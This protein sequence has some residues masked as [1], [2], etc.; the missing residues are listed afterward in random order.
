MFNLIHTKG[1]YMSTK[2][3]HLC[4]FGLLWLV[5]LSL[6][7]CIQPV[8][9]QTTTAPVANQSVRQGLKPGDKVG[10]MTLVK[11]PGKFGPETPPWAAFC[12]VSPEED[13]TTGTA[14]PG[15]YFVECNIPFVP[16]LYIGFPWLTRDEKLR[17]SIWA[18]ATEEHYLN[19]QLI[20]EAAFGT[21][22]TDFPMADPNTTNKDMVAKIRAWN[23]LLD[24]LTPGEFWLREV[25]HA[26]QTLAIG[27]GSTIP[28]GTYDITWKIT[29]AAPE[30]TTTADVTT[31]NMLTMTNP[32]MTTTVTQT[33]APTMTAAMTETATPTTT[34]AA[35]C[36]DVTYQS[37]GAPVRAVLCQPVG[38]ATQLPALIFLHGDGGASVLPPPGAPLG[39]EAKPMP[40]GL[41]RDLALKGYVTLGI[42]YFSQTPAPGP[43]PDSFDAVAEAERLKYTPT[44][45]RII[46]D[47]VTFLQSQPRV[48]PTRLGL[49]GWSRGGYLAL[50]DGT[51]NPAYRAVV[52]ISGFADADFA[53]HVTKMP[54]TLLLHGDVDDMV[55]VTNAYAVRDS[56]KAANRPVEIY[57]APGGNHLWLGQQ[58]RAGFAQLV[59]FLRKHL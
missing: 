46:D 1:L 53:Q 2:L 43:D 14:N 12:N 8:S 9:P 36:D 42:A 34:D 20:D 23:I 55:P 24:N 5:S 3:F 21:F 29:V 58:G 51:K 22:D 16:K 57:I 17:D 15:V 28:A 37:K 13:A 52:A 40:I 48:D 33:A 47:G 44:W 18:A 50:L 45:L 56:L 7:A 6:A 35:R 4:T 10:E 27:F 30:P 59:A 19:D 26:H 32:T 11:G 31:T 41:Y 25:Y 54:P 49:V 39:P 38:H